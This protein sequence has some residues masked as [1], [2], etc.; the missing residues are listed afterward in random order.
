MADGNAST[1]ATAHSFFSFNHEGSPSSAAS[2]PKNQNP[3]KTCPLI[4][5][6]ISMPKIAKPLPPQT[7]APFI[8]YA[9][10]A[11]QARRAHGTK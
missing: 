1:S 9:H 8:A 6:A 3:Q 5:G 10:R 2:S 7:T 11:E 4:E